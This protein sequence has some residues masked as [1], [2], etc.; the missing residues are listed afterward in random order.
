ML[1][2]L[3]AGAPVS[4]VPAAEPL[5][6]W[7]GRGRARLPEAGAGG[8]EPPPPQRPLLGL[9]GFGFALARLCSPGISAGLA[10]IGQTA[11]SGQRDAGWGP[12]EQ[13][14]IPVP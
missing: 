14:P 5:P 1:V 13:N 8:A 9:P 11:E 7:P 10:V 12:T 3:C 4:Q 6:A 2:L